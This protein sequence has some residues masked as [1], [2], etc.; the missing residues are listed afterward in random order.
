MLFQPLKTS[1]PEHPKNN[2]GQTSTETNTYP[3]FPPIFEK[4]GHKFE[5]VSSTPQFNTD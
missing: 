5:A 3:Q 1:D 4:Y 2:P